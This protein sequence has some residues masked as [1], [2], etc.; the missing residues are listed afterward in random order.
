MRPSTACELVGFALLAVAAWMLY[1]VAGVAVAGVSLL[2]IGY[3]LDDGAVA[4]SAK[5]ML[6][7]FVS[8]RIKFR[9]RRAARR[10]QRASAT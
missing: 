6:T 8:M 1:P 7:P 4:L 9:V 5:R 3:A 2:F 10:T